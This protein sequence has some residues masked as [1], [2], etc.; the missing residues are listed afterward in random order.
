MTR[1][2]PAL[3]QPW[4]WI[5]ATL[6]AM[7]AAAILV[8]R[9]HGV[10]ADVAPPAD[11]PPL[12]QEPTHQGVSDVPAPT[13]A[14]PLPD[15]LVDPSVIAE[16]ARRQLTVFSD[17]KAV[18]RYRV[19]L[20][21][22]PVLDKEREGDG[23][24]PEGT[25]Y[26]C[27]RNAASKYHRSIGLSYP[28]AEDAERGLA[29]KLITKREH[30]A[31]VEMLRLM[32]RPPWKTALGG[33]IMLHGGGTEG[34]WTQGCLALADEDAEELFRALPLGTPVEILP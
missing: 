11:E 5:A 14:H 17:G 16:K 22:D 12:A 4:I 1:M 32:R 9:S 13:D 26:V 3:R 34:D 2:E 31:I 18:K 23:R 24:T 8:V 15:I 33:E 7:L 19:V 6:A 10:G 28:N 20:G 21:A 27:S 30:R 25:F 29:T